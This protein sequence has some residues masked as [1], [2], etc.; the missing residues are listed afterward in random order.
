MIKIEKYIERDHPLKNGEDYKM[1]YNI[2]DELEIKS[3]IMV[4]PIHKKN[5]RSYLTRIGYSRGKEFI[6]RKVTDSFINVIRIK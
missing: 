5:F 3:S 4:C 2:V 6:T 1:A